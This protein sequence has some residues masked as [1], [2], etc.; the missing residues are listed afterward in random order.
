MN[1]YKVARYFGIDTEND[2]GDFE[3]RTNMDIYDA[4][5]QADNVFRKTEITTKKPIKEVVMP[6][7]EDRVIGALAEGWDK[8][9]GEA[10]K[11]IYEFSFDLSVLSDFQKKGIGRQLINNAIARYQEEKHVYEEMDCYTR[12][13]VWAVNANIARILEN[14]YGFDNEPVAYKDGEPVQW[15]CYKY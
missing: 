10:D 14:E 8:V 4:A 3:E 9:E 6:D 11:T 13:K 2:I 12:I 7:D 15:F 5:D 1:W